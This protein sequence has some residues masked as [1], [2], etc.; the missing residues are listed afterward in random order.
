MFSRYFQ[1]E[2]TYLRELGKAFAERHPGFAGLFAERGGDPDVTRLL[3]GFAFL[4]ARIRERIDDALPEVIESVAEMTI[5]Q[6]IR[7]TPSTSIVEFDLVGGAKRSFV[8]LPAGTLVGSRPASGTQCVF[9]TTV[10]IEVAPLTLHNA[11]LDL[12][13]PEAPTLSFRLEKASDQA[14]R[15]N[16]LRFFLAGPYGQSSTILLWLSRFLTRATING[17]PVNVRPSGFD[18]S[19]GLLPWPEVAP[20]GLREV[21]EFFTLPAKFLFF[22]IEGVGASFSEPG[23]LEVVFEFDDPPNLPERFDPGCLKLNCGPVVNLFE[24]DGDP[25]TLE[26]GKQEHLLRAAGFAPDDIEVY[27]V[28]SAFG[29]RRSDQRRRDFRPYY[30]L[31]HLGGG[32]ED[33]YYVLRRNHS[34]LDDGVDTYLLQANPPGRALEAGEEVLSLRLKCTNRRRTEG[35]HI[36]D[37]CEPT[38]ATPTSVSFSNVT[39]VS[40]PVACQPGAET[41][42]QTVAHLSANLMSIADVTPLRALLRAYNSHARGGDVQLGKANQRRIDAIVSV[43]SEVAHIV[44]GDASAPCLEVGLTLDESGFVS[45]GDAFLFASALED[46][47]VTESPINTYCQLAVELHPSKRVLKWKPRSG[48]QKP[49]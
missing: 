22:D 16:K 35:L 6:A 49:F 12:A 44:V 43:K 40:R 48:T 23:D 19:F 30:H 5:P 8:A 32:S 2:L 28:M 45:V 33:G 1:S 34:P 11:R 46:L 24:V 42:W 38:R 7:S 31:S 29:I 9:S 15:G 17:R 41:H 18:P 26:L 39:E 47:F 36:G 37:I 21:H 14:P 20:A 13:N 27:E 3:E 4:S 25:V 10:P